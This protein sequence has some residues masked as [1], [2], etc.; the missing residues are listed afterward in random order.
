MIKSHRFKSQN[1][2]SLI[3][4][5]QVNIGKT[6][7]CQVG[8]NVEFFGAQVRRSRQR[9]I[10][11]AFRVDFSACRRS[12]KIGGLNARMFFKNIREQG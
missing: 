3:E 9:D 1:D 6:C 5:D 11:I 7:A 4:D 10:E 12:K 2:V 8:E